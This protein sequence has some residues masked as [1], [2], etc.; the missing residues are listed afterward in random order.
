MDPQKW[1][2]KRMSR[3]GFL[4][5]TGAALG[6]GVLA[7]MRAPDC[8]SRGCGAGDG[9]SPAGAGDG[10]CTRAR[11][12][13]R[14]V[15]RADD[16]HQRAGQDALVAAYK[17]HQPDVDVVF[18]APPG[19][20]TGGYHSWL[21]TQLAADDIRL[22]IVSGVDAGTFRDYLNLDR[23]VRRPQSLRRQTLE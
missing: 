11:L 23:Y 9:G 21:T 19:D 6:T 1:Q 22:D 14:C 16:G 4:G 7:A 18:E 3:R 8:S 17:A 13:S 10:R 12:S 5:L 20:I 2:K 15:T